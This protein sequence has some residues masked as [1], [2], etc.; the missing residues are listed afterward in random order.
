M[1][2]LMRTNDLVRLSWAQAV[3]AGEGIESLVLDSFTS[4]IEGSIGIL[5]R[6][7]MVADR[8]LPRA[9]A[10]LAEAEP[11]RGEERDGA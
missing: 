3:L 6:R 4:G 7:L 10:A 2:E 11:A 8:D 9:R 5:P 1:V